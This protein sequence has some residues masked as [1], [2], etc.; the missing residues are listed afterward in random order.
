MDYDI[1]VYTSL[2]KTPRFEYAVDL[3]L[4]N[5]LGLNYKIVDDPDLSKPLI[6]YSNDRNIGGIYIQPEMILF[7]EGI[8]HQDIWVAHINSVPLFFQQPP[9]AGFM[10][11]IFAFSFYLVTRYEEYL[12]NARDEHGRYAAESSIAYKHNFLD[13]PVVDIWAHRLG[14][15]LKLLYPS[16]NIPEKKYDCLLTVDLDQPFA[17]RGKG[18]IRNIGGLVIDLINGKNPG[19]RF[20]CMAGRNKDPYATYDYI[21]KTAEKYNSPLMYFYTT[22]R[23]SKFDKNISP[24]R[25]CYKKLIRNLSKKYGIGLHTSYR[26]DN[27]KT[28][29]HKEKLRLEKVS[30]QEVAR[31][32]K[33]FL[34]LNLPLTYQ[35][36]ESM[37]FQEDYTL[38]YIREVG[39]RAGIARPFRFYDLS[40]EELSSLVLVPFQFMEGTYQKYKR[41]SPDQAKES[42]KNLIH[43]TRE[44]GGLFVSIWHNTSLNN[45][46]EWKGWR[47][48]FEFTLSEQKKQ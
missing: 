21:N 33:H 46:G 44:V 40:K 9:E 4:G 25:S 34:L 7:E 16:I 37:G 47:E 22:G 2:R 12:T 38:G 32:R 43:N 36:L 19:D 42:V 23:R 18:L 5:I 35:V 8:R 10:L 30:Q 6:N 31:V 3:V 13:L 17:Y 39:F 41:L 15:T 1:Q 14:E 48:L 27:N 29:I 24:G 28:M 11:D 45:I 26:S 20:Q